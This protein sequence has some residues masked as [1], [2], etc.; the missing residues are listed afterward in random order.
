MS[1]KNL[2]T[3]S[4]HSTYEI[5]HGLSGSNREMASFSQPVTYKWPIVHWE[6]FSA[7]VV[8][9][10][11]C[12]EKFLHLLGSFHTKVLLQWSVSVLM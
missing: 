10:N 11:T 3:N 7:F 6:Q 12:G 8:D 9:K 2:I 1:Y 5:G 4:T